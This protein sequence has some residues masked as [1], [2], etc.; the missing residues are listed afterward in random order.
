[1]DRNMRAI[2]FVLVVEFANHAK[3]S[4][5]CH[6]PIPSMAPIWATNMM[7]LDHQACSTT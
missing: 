4:S 2:L 6:E 3:I 1:M 7:H 5:H